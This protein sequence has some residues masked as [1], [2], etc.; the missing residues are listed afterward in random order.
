MLINRS[1]TLITNRLLLL[2]SI[3]SP[4][5]SSSSLRRR[6]HHNRSCS[7]DS[8]SSSSGLDI[9][10]NNF[11][12]R[13]RGT[14]TTILKSSSS[15]SS[16]TK[17]RN[18]MKKIDAHLHVWPS[19]NEYTYEDES[20][21]PTISG[22]VELL[23]DEQLKANVEGAMIVQPINLGFDH[24]YVQNAIV[25][26]KGKFVGCCLVNGEEGASEILSEKLLVPN[27]VFKAVRF[28][29]ALFP[30]DRNGRKMTN[31]EGKKMF[32]LCGERNALVG[33]MC[34]HGIDKSYD[35]ICELCREFPST[36]V[37][38][39]H[40]G[41]AKST[42]DKNWQKILDLSKFP[43]VY[44]KLSAQ[45]RVCPEN[46]K[47]EFPY[48]STFPQVVDLLQHFGASRLM[49]G[50]DYPFV[51]NEC[52]YENA[53]KIVEMNDFLTEE[54]KEMIFSGTIQRVFPDSFF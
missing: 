4:S 3:L 23:L 33:F 40:F 19:S 34:F 16:T 52:G 17:T 37:M 9:N 28:N 20:K 27:G 6:R 25:K 11:R 35:E 2:L 47:V 12:R 45:F 36:R 54:D 1:P 43:Q 38:I 42:S 7:S 48:E 8:S 39:D 32:K 18:T 51:K 15:S 26:Y 14:T 22:R 10:K 24:T 46:V 53:S 29:P 13:R 30:E 5:S 50:S 41:F 31:A 44:I 49:W 21:I